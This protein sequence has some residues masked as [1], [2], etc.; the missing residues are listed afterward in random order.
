MGASELDLAAFFWNSGLGRMRATGH[1]GLARAPKSPHATPIPT[2]L[3]I[4]SFRKHL[5]ADGGVWRMGGD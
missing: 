5:K 3:H 4:L 1:L 2:H